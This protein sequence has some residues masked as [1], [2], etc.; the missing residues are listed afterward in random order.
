MEEGKNAFKI[1]TG[2]P[3]GKRPLERPRGRRENNNRMDPKEIGI[4]TRI[5]IDSAQ[6]MDYWRTFVRH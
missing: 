1:L 4:N 2:T 3:T 5:W 6:D